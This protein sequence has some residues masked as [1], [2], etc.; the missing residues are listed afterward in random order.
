MAITAKI[1][2]DE[3]QWTAEIPRAK[4][5]VAT[6]RSLS[7]LRT[8]IQTGLREFYPTLAKEEIREVLELPARAK[9]VIEEIERASAQAE[10]AQAKARQMK[11]RGAQQLRK[12]LGLSI[13]D[14]GS[15]VG[16]S[17]AGVQQLL[18]DK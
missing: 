13:R 11:R 9:R 7:Q 4:G 14:V 16:I 1:Y 18:E 8:A 10:R 17:G 6:A 2:R 12:T 5:F 3:E 15:L